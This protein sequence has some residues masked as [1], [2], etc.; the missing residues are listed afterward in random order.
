M[1]LARSRG[2]CV[3]ETRLTVLTVKGRGVRRQRLAAGRAL[4]R[5]GWSV[6]RVTPC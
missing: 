3:A 4:L 1:Q 2:V 5:P 6:Y